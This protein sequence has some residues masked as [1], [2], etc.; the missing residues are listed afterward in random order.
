M[1]LDFGGGQKKQVMN[2]GNSEEFKMV[3]DEDDCV[4]LLNEKKKAKGKNLD[5]FYAAEELDDLKNQLRM[6]MPPGMM[7]MGNPSMSQP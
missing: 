6:N 2:F 4:D 5:E 3:E 7:K 1:K